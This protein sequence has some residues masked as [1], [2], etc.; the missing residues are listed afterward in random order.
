MCNCYLSTYLPSIFEILAPSQK[1][2]ESQEQV[3]ALSHEAYK[4]GGENETN[5]RNKAGLEQRVM[6]YILDILNMMCL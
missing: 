5:T 3:W 4:V 2:C 1:Y 6:H